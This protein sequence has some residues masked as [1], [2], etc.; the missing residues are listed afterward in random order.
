MIC[1]NKIFLKIIKILPKSFFCLD[2]WY[3]HILNCNIRWV[4]LEFVQV[5]SDNQPALVYILSMFEDWLTITL[6]IAYSFT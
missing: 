3:L 5:M 4:I 2:N 1:L 6:T